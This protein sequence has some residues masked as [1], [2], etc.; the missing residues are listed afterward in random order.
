[1]R[2]APEHWAPRR[3]SDADARRQGLGPVPLTG[4]IFAPV[5]QEFW[6]DE[7]R[8][9][10]RPRNLIGHYPYLYHW[11]VGNDGGVYRRPTTGD[12]A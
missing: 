3:V 9:I 6:D 12:H 8:P 10:Y 2:W 7:R 11:H 5:H 1:M 4:S